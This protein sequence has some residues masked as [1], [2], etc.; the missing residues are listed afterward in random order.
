MTDDRSGELRQGE[1]R[2]RQR[3]YLG[4]LR[5]RVS[6]GEVLNKSSLMR[7]QWK[8]SEIARHSTA[9]AKV[10]NAEIVHFTCRI[11]NHGLF[12][13]SLGDEGFVVGKGTSKGAAVL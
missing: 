11:T 4:V 7:L 12:S 2:L 8:M 6:P 3:G 1:C 9:M 10:F 5:K 13:T